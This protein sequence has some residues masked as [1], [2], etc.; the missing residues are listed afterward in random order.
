MSITPA[1]L[2]TIGNERT[3]RSKSQTDIDK[4]VKSWVA[5][6]TTRGIV[7]EASEDVTLTDEQ[8]NYLESA[9][10][11]AFKEGP[12]VT[13]IDDDDN[14]SKPLLEISWH[15][16]KERVGQGVTPGKPQEFTRFNDTF[17]LWPAPDTDNYPTL[18]IS[19]TIYHT[20]STTI[21][22]ADRFRECG[23]QYVIYKIYE[24]LGYLYRPKTT[25]HF[26][27]YEF[28]LDKL[29]KSESRKRHHSVGYNDI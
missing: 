23:I 11:N 17:Y 20:D 28:E 26:Q 15:R 16:Y 7:L 4:F 1:E 25:A 5:D 24:S 10:T 21:S 22:Y 19:G 3:G 27:S 6:L 18:R 9:L 8:A 14:E 29:L 2:R 13:V 12:V